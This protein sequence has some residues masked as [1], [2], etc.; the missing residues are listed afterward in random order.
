MKKPC[1]YCSGTGVDPP[2]A[3]RCMCCST[4]IETLREIKEPCLKYPFMAHTVSIG[5]S[6]RLGKKFKA[7][8]LRTWL[9]KDWK[10]QVEMIRTGR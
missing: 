2:F 4:L 8:D 10:A 1:H 5:D 6:I 7:K 3:V 9:G